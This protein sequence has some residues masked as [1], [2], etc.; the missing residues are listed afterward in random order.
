MR[1]RIASFVLPAIAY[2]A[3]AAFGQTIPNNSEFVVKLL[4]PIS[5]ESSKKG[6]KI[7]AQVMSPPEFQNAVME[8]TVKEAKSGGKINGKSVLNFTFE[9]LNA[10]S[11]PIPVQSSVKSMV[12]SQGKANVDEEGR[13]IEKKNNLGKAAIATGA[14][15]LIG[16]IAGGGKGAAIGAGVGAAA[17]LIFIEVA[18]KGANV[19]FAPGSQF[20]LE[21]KERR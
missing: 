14:G 6:D 11:G 10:K 9:T 3:P 8:G 17:S 15:A 16:G 19:N 13:V 18:V 21:V 1:N 2:L 4:G 20:V 5:T 7:T 12:N